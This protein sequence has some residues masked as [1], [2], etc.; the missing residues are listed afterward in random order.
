MRCKNFIPLAVQVLCGVQGMHCAGQTYEEGAA[1]LRAGEFGAAI[2]ILEPLAVQSPAEVRV[3][4]LLGIALSGA[5]RREEATLPFLQAL[6]INPHFLPALK[7]LALNELAMGRMVQARRHFEAVLLA[8]P[9]DGAAQLGMGQ[10]EYAEKHFAR[11]VV[12]YER[13]AGLYL[14]DPP[15]L[16]GFAVS[17]VEIGQAAKALAALGQLQAEAESAIHFEAGLLLARLSRYGDAARQFEFA[18]RKPADAYQVE[19]NLTLAYLKAGQFQQATVTAQAMLTAGRGSGEVY[20][21]LAQSLDASGR[22]DE[23][24]EALRAATLERP[25]EVGAYLELIAL[26]AEHENYERSMAIADI[27]VRLMPLSARMFS[28]RG[29]VLAMLGR[30]T[31][32]EGDLRRAQELA[33]GDTLVPIARSLVLLRTERAAEAVEELRRRKKLD[34]GDYLVN[35]FLAEALTRLGADDAHANGLEA[36]RAL[37][38]SVQ[39]NGEVAQ[40]RALLGKLLLARGQTVGAIVQLERALVLDPDNTAAT[41]QLAQAYRKEGN[42]ARASVLFEKVSRR[43]QDAQEDGTQLTRSG[44]LRIIRQKPQ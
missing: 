9:G 10:L 38:K 14:K 40:S 1:R 7:N 17:C 12:R 32:A 13:S 42:A 44:M 6:K 35:W 2:A 43:K 25:L 27:G 20:S 36:L 28:Q 21:L 23:A 4:N 34:G 30:F 37:E 15:A 39:L 16:L 41:Y 3:L 18:V 26:C 24:Y 11:A 19:F 29:I 5:G 33:P 8:V 22:T 31:D